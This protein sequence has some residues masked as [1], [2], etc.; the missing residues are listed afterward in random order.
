MGFD[1]LSTA[2]T[3]SVL[4]DHN[5]PV[6]VVPRLKEGRPNILDYIKNRQVGLIINTPSGP[7]P[8]KDEI[9]IRSTAV[10]HGIPLVTTVAGAVA[11]ADGIRDLQRRGFDVRSL[12]E[13]YAS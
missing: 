11:M 2:G 10:A 3:G 8:R 5:I 9:R 12:Q 7:I 13:I 6:T 4:Q 1:I